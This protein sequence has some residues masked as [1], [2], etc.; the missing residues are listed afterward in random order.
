[1]SDILKDTME[2]M[3]VPEFKTAFI[4]ADGLT[5]LQVNYF[6]QSTSF[7]GKEQKIVVCRYEPW[8]F[9]FAMQ[10]QEFLNRL[11]VGV[12]EDVQK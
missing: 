5:I 4:H 1:M 3:K 7:E 10:E 8:G 6:T 9:N 12:T 2:K 11:F